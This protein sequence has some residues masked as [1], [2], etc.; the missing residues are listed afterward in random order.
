M[1]FACSVSG[2]SSFAI[3]SAAGADMT[4]AAIRWPA[5]SGKNGFSMP[6][7]AA[8]TPPA[9]VAMPPT[10]TQCN[11]ER[12]ISPTY[13]L[14]SRGASVWPTKMLAEADSDS[15]PEVRQVRTMIHAKAFTMTCMKPR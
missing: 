4:D 1:V 5:M 7:K 14:M 12:V 6:T 8:I 10:I 9:T 3:T 11:S 2:I 13:G 15:A